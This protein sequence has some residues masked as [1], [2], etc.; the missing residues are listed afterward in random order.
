MNTTGLVL[1][2]AL[3]AGCAAPAAAADTEAPACE[4]RSLDGTQAV[5]LRELRGKIVYVDFWASWCTSCVKSFAFLNALDGEFRD[6]GL[7]IL[8]V[9]VDEHRDDALAFLAKRSASFAL[10]AD[11]SGSCPRAFG[12]KGMP[13]SYLIDRRGRIRETYVGFRAGEASAIRERVVEL[14]AEPSGD[15]T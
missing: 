3:L 12:V 10:A 9:N 13:S 15:A 1:T 7:H 5:D 8:G 11:T 2:F 14:L 4:L 6:E